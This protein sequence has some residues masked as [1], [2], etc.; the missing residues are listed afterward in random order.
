MSY[1]E[2]IQET[3]TRQ[4]AIRELKRHSIVSLEEFFAEVGDRAEYAAKD[5][6]DWLG[7]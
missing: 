1:E 4:Q 6:L 7:Y 5:V 2:A 3:V